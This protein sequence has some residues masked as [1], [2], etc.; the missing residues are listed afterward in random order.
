MIMDKILTI[1]E[2]AKYLRVSRTTVWRWCNEGE[3]P[4]FKAGHSWRV[5]RSDVE[6]VIGRKLEEIELDEDGDH[7]R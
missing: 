2:I 7:R 4:A 6:K 5:F 1:P 3:L